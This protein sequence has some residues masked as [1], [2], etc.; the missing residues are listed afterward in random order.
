MNKEQ[1]QP[2]KAKLI[3]EKSD[4]ALWGRTKIKGNLIVD[5]AKTL[6][7]LKKQLKELAYELENVEI[8]DF[9][10]SYDLTT[11]FESHSYLNI[12]DVAKRAG[13][14]AAL[15]RQ[16][17]SGVKFPSEERVDEIEK[18]IHQIGKELTKIKLH[19][20]QKEAMA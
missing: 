9:E 8:E 14:N 6:L 1:R 5:S 17:A 15:M 3:V 20:T 16:Y 18:A 13:I 19:K 10:V 7:Q 12:T 2:T 4:G 11:F